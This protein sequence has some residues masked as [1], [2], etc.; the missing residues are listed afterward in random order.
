MTIV[1]RMLGNLLYASIG[2]LPLDHAD[3][4]SAAVSRRDEESICKSYMTMPPTVVSGDRQ[5]D[6]PAS[7]VAV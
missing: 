6:T 2:G 3:K 5:P 1:I 7:L 4:V